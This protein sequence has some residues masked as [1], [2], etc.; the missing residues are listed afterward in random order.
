MLFRAAFLILFLFNAIALS[1]DN[2]TFQAKVIGVLDGD[3]I[4]VLKDKVPLRIRLY[5]IDCPEHD[6]DFGTRAKQFTSD[7]VFG[8]TV[9]VVPVEKDRYER[10]VAKIYIDGKYLNQMIVAEGFAWW[11]KRY[12]PKDAVLKEAEE[13]A[14]ASR[15]GLWSHPNPI[16]PWKFRRQK[17]S[18][19]GE[20]QRE[21]IQNNVARQHEIEGFSYARMAALQLTELHY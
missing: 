17:A 15:K 10:L 14:R 16:P 2:S 11:Y 4:E 21:L 6:Q 12:A 19:D 18:K 5:G 8:K 20:Y 3:T 13:D 9:E 7:K 1:S